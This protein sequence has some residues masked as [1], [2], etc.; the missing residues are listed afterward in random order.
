MLNAYELMK[1]MIEAGAAGVHFEDQLA[2][3]KKN[4]A[5][6]AARY[7]YRRRKP[8]RSWWP[9]AWQLT[10]PACRLSFW[11]VPTPTPLTC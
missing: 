5:T 6:W 4:A 9:R 8:Y 2:S 10:F 11:P 3:V 7:W 1:N